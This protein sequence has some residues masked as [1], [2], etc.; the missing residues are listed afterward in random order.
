MHK[1]VLCSIAG[2]A[3]ALAVSLPAA[4][5][6]ISSAAKASTAENAKGWTPSRTP[7]GQPD[8]QGT[9]TNATN[10]PLERPKELGAKEFY[11]AQEAAALAK[12]GF[13]GERNAQPVAHYDFSQYGMDAMQARFAP[14]LRTSLIVGPEG[15]IPPLIPEAVK[16]NADRAAKAKGHEFD[17]PENRSLM[18]RCI[19]YGA[20]EGPPML[21]PMYNNNMEIVQGPG[22]VAILNEMYHDARIIPLD[23]RPH[24]P[25]NIRQW[26]GDSR[27]HWDG[28][29]LV[30]DSTNFTAQT[31]FHGSSEN[32]H[33]VERFTRT[34]KNTI[35]YQF[36]VDDPATWAKPWSAELVMGPALGRIYEFACHE[37]NY[38]MANNLSGARAEEKK[39]AEEAAKNP[40][41]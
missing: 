10:K 23:G 35:L 24:L 11:T 8:L 19:V 40:S 14:N 34:G 39:A 29:T 26:R 20:L 5:Q 2:F 16:R 13:L 22:Y 1:R 9:W 4:G 6:A 37:G 3:A 21:P 12:K 38:G 27:G 32:L 17:G 36:T 18:E 15:R 28:N 33:V 7:D 31:A 41:K 30:V 25:Q